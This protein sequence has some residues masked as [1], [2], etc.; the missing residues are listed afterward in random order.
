MFVLGATGFIHELLFAHS[1]RP[2]LIAAS[3][4]LMGLPLAIRADEKK[5]GRA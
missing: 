2:Y 1:E 3:L 4:A 5:N